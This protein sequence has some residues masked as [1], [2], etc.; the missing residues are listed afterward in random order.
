MT[1]SFPSS[2]SHNAWSKKARSGHLA[3]MV[4]LSAFRVWEEWINVIF[5]AW[6]VICPWIL[7]ISSSVAKINLIVVGL[8]V[9]ALAFYEIWEERRQTSN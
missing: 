8:L 2:F 3:E 5:G 4:T 6:L 7:G 1:G 9:M